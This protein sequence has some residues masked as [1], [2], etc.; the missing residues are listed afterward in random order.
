[1]TVYRLDHDLYFDPQGPQ[2]TA[3]HQWQQTVQI[4]EGWQVIVGPNGGY[5][6][7]L[8]LKGIEQIADTVQQPS[9]PLTCN[10]VLSASRRISTTWSC[11]RSDRLKLSLL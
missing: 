9:L 5:I 10:W 7:A 6:G 3:P 11:P 2:K 8:L 1:M 4:S